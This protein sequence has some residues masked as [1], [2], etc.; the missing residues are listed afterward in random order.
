MLTWEAKVIMLIYKA[1]NK[2]NGKVYIGQTKNSLE[3]RKRQHLNSHKYNSF[4]CT[5]FSKA[6][7]K[8]GEEA[9]EWEVLATTESVDMLDRL[10][11]MYISEYQSTDPSKGY[12][13]TS[14][15]SNG[16]SHSDITKERIGSAQR[17]TKNHMYGRTGAL[18][19]T[20]K[21][22]IDLDTKIIYPSAT[23]CAQELGLSLS[24]VCAVCRGDRGSTQGKIFRYVGQEDTVSKLQRKTKRIYNHD[25]QTMYYSIK[26]A[27]IDLTGD[28]K[29]YSAL[30][31]TIKY[32]KAK[33]RTRLTW[34]GHDIELVDA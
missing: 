25:K 16:Y 22:V 15:G 29:S 30:V 28:D 18:N 26:E 13:L 12:N 21:E 19:P 5:H 4:R 8:Y 32:N 10:E 6:I 3:T 27:C 31:N 1:K 14:G 34:R 24:K 17:G 11:I 2:L 33:E 9:F 20:S 7:E 23:I